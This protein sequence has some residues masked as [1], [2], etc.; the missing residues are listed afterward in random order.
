M[1]GIRGKTRKITETREVEVIVERNPAEM[2]IKVE[3]NLKM[4]RNILITML[5]D[6]FHWKGKHKKERTPYLLIPFRRSHHLDHLH[7]H[8]LGLEAASTTNKMIN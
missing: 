1:G 4:T 8:A 3:D 7:R 2:M 5:N 6:Q